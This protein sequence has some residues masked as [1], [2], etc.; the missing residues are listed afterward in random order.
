MLESLD[1]AVLAENARKGYQAD[2]RM[3]RR[4]C[5]AE[6]LTRKVSTLERHTCAIAWVHRQA[7]FDSPITARVRLLLRAARRFRPES[8]RQVKPLSVAKLRLIAWAANARR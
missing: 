3:F 7:G 5:E 2:L 8:L 6:H 4:W 1:Q